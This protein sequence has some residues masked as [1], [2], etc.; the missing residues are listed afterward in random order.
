MKLGDWVTVTEVGADELERYQLVG[1]LE[2]IPWP[3]A[4]PTKARWAGCWWA[5]RWA[6]WCASM[7][8]VA[9]LS[10]GWSRSSRRHP[11]IRIINARVAPLTRPRAFFWRKSMSWEPNPLEEQRLEKLARLQDEGIDP[12]P[13]R[14]ERTHTNSEA[15]ATFEAADEG[16]PVPVTV[17]GR[18]ISVRDMGKTIFA[19]S[20]TR[21]VACNCSCVARTWARNP[22][23]SSRSCSTWATL[24]RL[25]ARCSAPSW[26]KSAFTCVTGAS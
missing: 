24:C 22:T 14:V 6:K 25:V 13:L 10:F 16:V 17:C 11:A 20:P 2:L 19:T 21:T 3:G 8:H 9:S 1:P 7:R 5:L 15:I 4:S 26:A 12:Y 18:L 23:P